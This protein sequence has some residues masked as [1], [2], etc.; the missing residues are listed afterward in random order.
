MV[1][2]MSEAADPKSTERCLEIGTGSGYQ[3]AVLAE[4]CQRVYSIEYLPKVAAFG[5]ANLEALGYTPG[6]VELRVGDGFKGWPEAAPFQTILVTAAPEQVPPPL[7]EQL[8]VGGRLV[9]PVGPEDAVQQLERWTRKAPGDAPEA[10][11]RETLMGVR[12]VPFLGDEAR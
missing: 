11:E 4:L 2:A 7:L 3:A 12:F 8:D 9:I 5:K 1:A 10:F 6:R